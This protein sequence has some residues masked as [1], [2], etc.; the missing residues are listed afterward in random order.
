M[1]AEPEPVETVL[2]WVRQQVATPFDL[3]NEWPY[4]CRLSRL[5]ENDHALFFMAHHIVFDGWSFDIFYRELNTIYQ[6]RL[7]G[8]ATAAAGACLRIPRL[9]P[10][11]ARG[12]FWR[13]G[14]CPGRTL[15]RP[16]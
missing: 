13:G 5:G 2:D 9:L 12:D 11:E 7:C 15:A 1:S 3:E 8:E 16:T 10:L 4:R 14:P 6:A